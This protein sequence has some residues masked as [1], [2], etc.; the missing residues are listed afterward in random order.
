MASTVVRSRY[1]VFGSASGIPN[2]GI[3][4]GP[5]MDLT[6]PD[7]IINS[8]NTHKIWRTNESTGA[9]ESYVPG[10]G[11]DFTTLDRG[12]LNGQVDLG[13]GLG[14]GYVIIGKADYLLPYFTPAA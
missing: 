3:Y 6:S 12:S 13:K 5:T 7:C 8:T 1:N 4:F 14:R 9:W 11:G 10:V 2:A